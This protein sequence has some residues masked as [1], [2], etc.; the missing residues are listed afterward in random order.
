VP[1]VDLGSR[2][3]IAFAA[4]EQVHGEL[5]SRLRV[6]AFEHA[7]DPQLARV[8]KDELVL[9]L[10]QHLG[11]PAIRA[12]DGDAV[13]RRLRPQDQRLSRFDR[14]HLAAAR[15]AAQVADRVHG[16]HRKAAADD[17]VRLRLDLAL[18]VRSQDLK[19]QHGVLE[20]FAGGDRI[21][22]P[23]VRV[24]QRRSAG[25][26]FQRRAFDDQHVAHFDV[27][28]QRMHA[29]RIDD[30]RPDRLR[31]LR[32]A[33]HGRHAADQQRV[34]LRHGLR[35]AAV[36][37][38]QVPVA[39]GRLI[40]VLLGLQLR[41]RHDRHVG[42]L[43][44][45][46]GVQRQS[47]R[48]VARRH[49]QDARPPA[50][51][52]R[53]VDA[54]VQS[55]VILVIDLRLERRALGVG[56]L[57]LH[58]GMAVCRHRDR[59]GVLQLAVPKQR[60]VQAHLVVARV[61]QAGERL[62]LLRLL[63][64]AFRRE[65]DD[66]HVVGRFRADGDVLRVQVAQREIGHGG[67]AAVGVQVER[68]RQSF[69]DLHVVGVFGVAGPARIGQAGGGP[70][71]LAQVAGATGRFD[72]VHFLPQQR[73]VAGKRLFDAGHVRKAD[74]Q[75]HVLRL[76]LFDQTQDLLFGRFQPRGLDVRGRHA[77]RRVDQEDEPV[78]RQ[79][80]PAP[81]RTQASGHQDRD[82]QQLQ[83]Q[84]QALPQ[85]LPDRVDVQVLDRAAPQ[86]RAGHFQRLPF[87]LQEIQ[88]HDGRGHQSQDSPLPKIQTIDKIH[89]HTRR[90]GCS[91]DG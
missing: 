38:D 35:N 85:T 9:R 10:A 23:D 21:H 67:K 66:A 17:P 48:F 4:V 83:E 74:H 47:Q 19:P 22:G 28:H 78:A 33:G 54:I 63:Q 77:G 50:A 70:Q 37:D 76:H 80:R 82:Q 62:P 49:K 26:R 11:T 7:V 15:P 52:H 46:V 86:I 64:V 18:V 41:R 68:G 59:L 73:T 20:T 87:E 71:G 27:L 12:S 65:S 72:L 56:Q 14:R 90:T 40:Q 88:R 61:L 34:G 24:D 29:V 3:Q 51:I 89:R 58:A 84:Q 1:Q 32:P 43:A 44:G 39:R 81:A 8:G 5:P 57:E 55:Q 13:H 91:N 25:R 69:G 16:E 6:A 53:G 31:A 36:V 75:G 2:L 60:H 42:Q 45:F 79:S 30:D